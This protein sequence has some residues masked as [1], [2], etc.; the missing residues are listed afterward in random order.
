[1]VCRGTLR[2]LLGRYLWQDPRRL[3]FTY[4]FHGKP[5]LAG[6]LR[7]NVAHS[8]RLALIAMAHDREVGV[9]LER[10]RPLAAADEIA[11]QYFSVLEQQALH[12]LPRRLRTKAFFQ[13]WTRNEAYVK[14]TGAGLALP[15]NRFDITLQPGQPADLLVNPDSPT[16]LGQWTLRQLSPGPG[17]LGA[18]AVEGLSYKLWC[19]Q[20]GKARAPE[21]LGPSP[22]HSGSKVSGNSCHSTPY[23]EV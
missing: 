7:F 22:Q 20:W 23:A 13:C 6:K 2:T 8:D 17:Y 5:S 9:D 21:T 18:I 19:G 1:V 15:L 12:A 11:R 16:K 10:V 4:G 14:A 3:H